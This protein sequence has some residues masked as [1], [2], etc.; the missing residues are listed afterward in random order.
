MGI[1]KPRA[2]APFSVV[3]SLAPDARTSAIST[4]GGAG[5][6]GAGLRLPPVSPRSP[7]SQNSD[8]R[9]PRERGLL[10]SPRRR[11]SLRTTATDLP[12][13]LGAQVD[14]DMICCP[15]FQGLASTCCRFG[16]VEDRSA[17]GAVKELQKQR[18][19]RRSGRTWE[20][21]HV[22]DFFPTALAWILANENKGFDLELV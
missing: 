2:P 13:V 16:Q 22:G 21:C 1:T 9:S 7:R 8:D 15:F 6:P 18:E 5:S 10:G 3:P 14:G 12:E 20:I 4:S 19:R 17:R 11:R